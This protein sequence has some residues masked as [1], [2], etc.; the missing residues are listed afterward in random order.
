MARPRILVIDD[1]S[2]VIEVFRR[3][4]CRDDHEVVSAADGA[5]GLEQLRAA[6]PDVVFSDIHMPNTDGLDFLEQ[7]HKV[8]P[9]L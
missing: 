5:E 8:D 1:E 6:K 9:D 7:A 4:I 3:G 2:T